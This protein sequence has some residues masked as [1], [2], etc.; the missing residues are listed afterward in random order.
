[1]G[2][3]TDWVYIKF[4]YLINDDDPFIRFLAKVV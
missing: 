4:G 3:K 1:M 2:K